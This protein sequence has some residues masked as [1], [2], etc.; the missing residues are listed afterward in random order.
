VLDHS[1][2]FVHNDGLINIMVRMSLL[3]WLW[4]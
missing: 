3:S 4:S 1:L 2:S